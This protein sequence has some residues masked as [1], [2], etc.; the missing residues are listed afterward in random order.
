MSIVFVSGIFVGAIAGVL[1]M[2]II[3]INREEKED[4]NKK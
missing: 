2:A 3:Q 1:I 4:A